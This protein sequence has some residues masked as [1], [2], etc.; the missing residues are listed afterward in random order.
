MKK[1]L[2]GLALALGGGFS[3]CTSGVNVEQRDNVNF[4]Q[5]RTF[6]FA[7]TQVKTNGNQNPLLHSPIAQDHIKQAIASELA[8][9]GLRQVDN[10]PDL[11]VTTHT[12]VDEAERT[13]YSSYPGAGFTYPYSVGYRGAFLPSTTATTTRPPTTRRPIPSSTPR[14][15]SSLTSLT[16]A[17]TTSCGAARWPTRLMTPAAWAASSAPRPRVFWT[18][19]R[20]KKS[21]RSHPRRRPATLVA[22][23]LRGWLLRKLLERHAARS[24]ALRSRRSVCHAWGRAAGVGRCYKCLAGLASPNRLTL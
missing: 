24:E 8:R 7:D 14:A 19:F 22:G 12:Y 9:R 13:V 17:L 18:S 5:Y 10:S 21:S 1:I 6:D 15:R 2:L 16:A 4:A 3:A 11:L 23:L 20:L